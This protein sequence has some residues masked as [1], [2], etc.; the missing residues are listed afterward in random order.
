LRFR[1]GKLAWWRPKGTSPPTIA[2]GE[3]E[4]L[5]ESGHRA[6]GGRHDAGLVE[7]AGNGGGGAVLVERWRGGSRAALR[8]LEPT[9]DFES[10]TVPQ[11]VEPSQTAASETQGEAQ[12]TPSEAEAEVFGNAQG[13][14]VSQFERPRG[15]TTTAKTTFDEY[16]RMASIPG[17]YVTFYSA[18]TSGRW[19]GL[20]VED[21]GRQR[22][23]AEN[24]GSYHWG[25]VRLQ[26]N[27]AFTEFEG[28]WDHCGEGQTWDWRGKRAGS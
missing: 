4:K 15:G 11:A 22:C 14:W 24:G 13:R 3:D 10:A 2:G 23:T 8:G 25:V 1:Q 5:H 27:A 18:D 9:K 6:V 19:E 26:F 17:P 21:S 16:G 7:C 12:V 28:S 20:W